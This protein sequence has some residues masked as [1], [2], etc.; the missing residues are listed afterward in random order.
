VATVTGTDYRCNEVLA[1]MKKGPAL[2]IQAAGPLKEDVRRRGHLPPLTGVIPFAR[3][4]TLSTQKTQLQ[5]TLL[6]KNSFRA[7][8]KKKAPQGQ[9][10]L[11]GSSEGELSGRASLPLFA[12]PC[13][14]RI[15]GKAQ[16]RGNNK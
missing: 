11:R 5:D 3:S 12:G 9:E 10:Q 2:W 16:R 1:Q 14:W 7:V 4:K 8:D 6:R 13:A 15:G